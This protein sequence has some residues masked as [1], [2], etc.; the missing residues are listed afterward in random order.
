MNLKD[1]LNKNDRYAAAA[2]AQIVEMGD[3]YAKVEM[4]VGDMH[5]N[6]AEVCQGGAIFTLA[7]LAFAAAVNSCGIMTVGTGA[8][9]TFLRS[10]RRGD[11]LT[12]EAREVPH[13]K[14]PFCEVRV[15]N[16]DGSLIS[17]MTGNAY[18]KKVPIMPDTGK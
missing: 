2:G 9:I 18:R 14:M 4:V 16:Q 13:P 1:F 7:D 15:V 6:G 8:N 17:V 5:I 3:G 10:A 12:A 11:K